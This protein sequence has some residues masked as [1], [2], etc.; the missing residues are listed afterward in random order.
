M[1]NIPLRHITDIQKEPNL[2]GSFVIR[3]VQETLDG[4]DMV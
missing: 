3:D 4:K 1:E 2:L